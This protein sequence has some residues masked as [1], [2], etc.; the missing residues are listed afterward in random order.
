[1]KF[2]NCGC[3]RLTII[4]RNVR[5]C[6]ERS[7]SNSSQTNSS[8][9]LH[10]PPWSDGSRNRCGQLG[11]AIRRLFAWHPLHLPPPPAAWLPWQ[12]KRAGDLGSGS[13]RARAWKLPW[14]KDAESRAPSPTRLWVS[15]DSI[16]Y[17]MIHGDGRSSLLSS[18]LSSGVNEGHLSAESVPLKNFLEDPHSTV[19]LFYS[20]VT[21]LKS[22]YKRRWE[23]MIFMPVA[24]SPDKNWS[25][26]L[27]RKKLLGLATSSLCHNII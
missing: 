24:M 1:M 4:F 22:S 15:G 26:F 14:S 6:K 20:L 18:S 10:R 13:P 12:R 16:F 11:V 19:L 21:W 23:N 5:D 2:R 17:L 7:T 25:I 8:R 27:R 3:G 9:N